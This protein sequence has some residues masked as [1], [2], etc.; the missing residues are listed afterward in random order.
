MKLL[1]DSNIFIEAKNRYY[2]FDICP[3]FWEWMDNVC[4]TDVGTIV[5][6]RDELFEGKDDLAAWAK[7]RRDAAWFLPVDDAATQGNFAAVVDAVAGGGYKDA[8]I[9]KFLAK[10]DPWLIAKAI[11]IGATII[12]HEV[13]EPH[14][15]RR[16]PIPNVCQVF[17]V[18]CVN[19]F[20]ALRKF[21]TI[22]KLG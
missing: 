13:I 10:A 8:A 7:E 22:F 17:G 4:G 5:N 14:S 21:S 6:V 9:E 18:P 1:L 15:K 12:T 11:T 3:G 20:D 19:T 2:A 16:V